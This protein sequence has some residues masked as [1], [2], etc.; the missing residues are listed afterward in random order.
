MSAT[1]PGPDLAS[2]RD[3]VTELVT[4]GEAFRDVENAIREAVDL[5]DEQKSALWLFAF[6][7][8]DQSEQQAAAR[9]HLAFVQ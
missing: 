8:R 7:L 5:T 2:Y 6:S 3:A 4:R 9:V 1:H